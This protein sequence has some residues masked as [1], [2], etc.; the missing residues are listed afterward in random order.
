MAVAQQPSEPVEPTRIVVDVSEV[1]VR[2][3]FPDD[4]VI[5]TDSIDQ[6]TQTDA[7]PSSKALG[8]R[9]TSEE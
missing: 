4:L 2:I 3:L 7:Y 9:K 6:T 1:A 8:P 5:D